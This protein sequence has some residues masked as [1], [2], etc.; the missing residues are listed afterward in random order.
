MKE[1]DLRKLI[2]RGNEQD[3]KALYDALKKNHPELGAKSREQ[4]SA[5]PKQKPV[6]FKH[7]VALAPLAAV[8]VFAITMLAV[9]FANS[10]HYA[11]GSA[12]AYPFVSGEWDL[13]YWPNMINCT[14]KEYADINN[15]SFLYCDGDE[16]I[17]M[18]VTE[19]SDFQTQAFVGLQV[20]YYNPANRTDAT[21]FI[22]YEN[23]PLRFLQG[24][25]DACDNQAEVGDCVVKWGADKNV[26]YGSF[27][28]GG[29][30]YY[31]SVRSG[32]SAVLFD[33]VKCLLMSRR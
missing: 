22:Y 15:K 6:F 5:A 30:Q 32:D 29:Y 12:S 17:G 4:R 7:A 13:G 27:D 10:P 2:C 14:V 8:I 33:F 26:A 28:Y 3:N 19:Y 20:S 31:V 24:N 1:R 9:S 23:N 25:I 11:S 16:Y 21:C 18:A